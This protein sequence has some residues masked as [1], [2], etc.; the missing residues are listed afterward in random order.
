MDRVYF[1]KLGNMNLLKT[2]VHLLSRLVFP[3]RC[4]LC[5]R[6]IFELPEDDNLCNGYFCPD[7]SEALLVPR[8]PGCPF[9]GA[10]LAGN[11]PVRSRC[12]YCDHA[13]FDFDRVVTL[14]KYDGVLRD[15]VLRIKKPRQ[16]VLTFA[17]A[18]AFCQLRRKDIDGFNGE[19]IVPIPMNP[20]RRKERE[21]TNDTELLAER[22]SYRLGIPAKPLLIRPVD[23]KL[24]RSLRPR[25][26]Q[27][28]MRDAFRMNDLFWDEGDTIPETV[29]LVDDVLT[30]GA[31]CSEAARTLKNAGAKNVFVLVLARAVGAD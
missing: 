19:V 13:N 10:H 11:P 9:C 3:P 27:E 16:Q 4:V 15:A 30:T 18:D 24:Q 5:D 12:K 23:T 20:T 17:L 14:G 28:N 26:R 22:I 7:C 8:W 1:Q 29:L 21:G 25:E 31:T 2:G 6:E